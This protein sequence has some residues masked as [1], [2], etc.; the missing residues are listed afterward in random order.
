MFKA[1][2]DS[3]ADFYN[4][5]YFEPECKVC[6]AKNEFISSLSKLLER[7]NE[8]ANG[9]QQR[10]DLVLRLN[11]SNIGGNPS[12][13]ENRASNNRIPSIQGVQSPIKERY[14]AEAESR[15]KYWAERVKEVEEIDRRAIQNQVVNLDASTE[16]G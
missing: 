4:R 6:K 12:L 7:E 11:V 1:F 13:S 2:A 10:L 3:I 15:R 5:F 14:T 9:L 8:R 16:E